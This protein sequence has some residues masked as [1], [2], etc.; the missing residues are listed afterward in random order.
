M[1]FAVIRGK[2]PPGGSG[3]GLA[4]IAAAVGPTARARSAGARR[5]DRAPS[6]EVGTAAGRVGRI[7]YIPA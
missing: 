5:G 2:V 1:G 3:A 7:P 4:T 6:R